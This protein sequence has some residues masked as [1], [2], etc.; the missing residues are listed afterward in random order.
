[1]F[2]PKWWCCVRQNVTVWLHAIQS[3]SRTLRDYDYI[4][5]RGYVV[6]LSTEPDNEVIVGSFFNEVGPH[7]PQ[8]KRTYH[9]CRNVQ[10]KKISYDIGNYFHS[11]RQHTK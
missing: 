6:L 11:K 7:V 9:A 10:P 4:A 5:K 3:V 2:I 8:L 1:M